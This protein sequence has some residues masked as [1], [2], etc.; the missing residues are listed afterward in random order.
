MKTDK[1]DIKLVANPKHGGVEWR[2]AVGAGNANGPGHYPKLPVAYDNDGQFTF[3]IL[4]SKATFAANPI[5]VQAGTGKPS[6]IDPQFTFTGAGTKTLT[7]HDS[8]QKAAD[9]NYVLHFSDGSTLDPIIQNG[10]CCHTAHGGSSTT[11]ALYTA[12]ALGIIVL[13]VLLVLLLRP[14]MLRRSAARD[15]I[16][17]P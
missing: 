10:G 4:N 1:A 14:V 8:N 12:G 2:M 9:Y 17:R 6:G 15:D 3:T 7:V 13:L 5:E 16:R 11:Y